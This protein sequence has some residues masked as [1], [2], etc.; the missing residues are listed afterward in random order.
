MCAATSQKLLSDVPVSLKCLSGLKILKI[1]M[2]L[3]IHASCV[4]TCD[5]WRPHHGSDFALTCQDI[6]TWPLGE[7]GAVPVVSSTSLLTA[8]PLSLVGYNVGPKLIGLPTACPVKLRSW[9]FRGLANPLSFLSLL[10]VYISWA[11]L[12]VWLR[13]HAG[14]ATATRGFTLSVTMFGWVLWVL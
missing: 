11:D 4:K 12:L 8:E 5:P 3:S 1:Q 10:M 9:E 14:G 7:G 13:T 6:D 2:W